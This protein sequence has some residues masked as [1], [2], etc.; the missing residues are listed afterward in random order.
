MKPIAVLLS[1]CLLISVAA[2]NLTVGGLNLKNTLTKVQHAVGEMPV[3]EEVEVG[4][5]VTS[6]LLGAAPLVEQEELQRYLNRVGLWVA[7]HCERPDLPWRFG[8]IDSPNINAFAAP[9]GYVLITRGLFMALNSE[10]E[11][12]AVL[13][14]EIGHVVERHH[15]EALQKNARLDLLG[16]VVSVA[17][18][19]GDAENRAR[20]DKLVNAGTQLYARGLDREDEF[21]A[22]RRGVVYAARA[23]YDPFAL[24][25]VLTTLDSLKAD[26]PALALLTRTHPPFGRRLE[27]LD[28]AIEGRMDGY[29]APRSPAE[30]RLLAMQRRLMSQD[31]DEALSR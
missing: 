13:G 24:L 29:T 11:L 2:C 8:V 30:G 14:H 9:G 19:Q 18:A 25:D 10:A 22:D 1:L 4:G 26:T 5:V 12:A 16:D 20:L 17:A 15:L 21:E 28:R 27:R 3:E 31:R 23:G 6:T 7:Q